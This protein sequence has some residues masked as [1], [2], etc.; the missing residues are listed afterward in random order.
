LP[1]PGIVRLHIPSPNKKSPDALPWK[2]GVW[3]FLSVWVWVVGL[4]FV[5][6]PCGKRRAADGT[7]ACSA[8]FAIFKH[9]QCRKTAHAKLSS[10]LGVFVDIDF[11]WGSR[12]SVGLIIFVNYFCCHPAGL[13]SRLLHLLKVFPCHQ[14]VAYLAKSEREAN[15]P[16]LSRV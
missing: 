16:S 4:N 3:A 8:W 2:L 1:R 12:D 9:H 7:G 14:A 13:I 11:P 15:R 6:G 10:G 5:L